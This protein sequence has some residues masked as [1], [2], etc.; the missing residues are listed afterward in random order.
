MSNYFTRLTGKLICGTTMLVGAAALGQFPQYIA[1]YVQ[2]ADGTVKEDRRIVK[3]TNGL[4]TEAKTEISH[5]AN[6]L[7]ASLNEIKRARGLSRLTTFLSKADWDI[8]KDTYSDYTPGM[9]F[10][11]DGIKYG[12]TGAAA[13]F[14]LYEITTLSASLLLRRK[15]K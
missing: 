15:K 3:N 9:T 12:V 10:N 1:Q 11:S 5:R 13:G 7:E 8:A 14:G 2:R 6:I 4:S